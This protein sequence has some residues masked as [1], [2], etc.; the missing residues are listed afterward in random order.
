MK[1]YWPTFLWKPWVFVICV[2]KPILHMEMVILT[3]LYESTLPFTSSSLI[4]VS[5]CFFFSFFSLGTNYMLGSPRFRPW[6]ILLL[7]LTGEN[8]FHDNVYRLLIHSLHPVWV[9]DSQ[10]KLYSNHILSVSVS[11]LDS[12][13]EAR[14]LRVIIVLE[15]KPFSQCLPLE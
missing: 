3:F 6:F 9:P 2:W 11:S 13:T 8:G 1:S 14:K 10:I 4:F 5:S 7:Y 15:S 12:S